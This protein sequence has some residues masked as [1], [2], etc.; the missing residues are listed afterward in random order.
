MNTAHAISRLIVSAF[1]ITVDP[2]FGKVG[3]VL[4]NSSTDRLVRCIKPANDTPTTVAL[5]S[6]NEA[7]TAIG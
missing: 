3:G 2:D 6:D 7:L 5:H 4:A 1:F